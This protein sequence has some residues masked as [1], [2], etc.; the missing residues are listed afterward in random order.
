MKEDKLVSEC[1]EYLRLSNRC[2]GVSGFGLINTVSLDG[3]K[4]W[5]CLT[6]ESGM[7]GTKLALHRGEA[8]SF[9]EEE[10]F[11]GVDGMTIS[12]TGEEGQ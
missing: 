11:V 7:R 3:P 1:R 5:R 8:E 6:G 12:L 10:D 9:F 4:D 2:L